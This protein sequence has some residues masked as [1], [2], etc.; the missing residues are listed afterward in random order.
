MVWRSVVWSGIIGSNI[1]WRRGE[2][3]S[4]VDPKMV[5]FRIASDR[6]TLSGEILGGE[7]ND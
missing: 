4:R 2:G 6:G 7:G 1:V 3:G 5:W